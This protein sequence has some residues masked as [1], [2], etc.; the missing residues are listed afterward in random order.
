[1][2]DNIK[3]NLSTT[4]VSTYAFEPLVGLTAATNPRGISTQYTYDNA[5]R[6]STVT[7]TKKNVVSQYQYGYVDISASTVQTTNSMLN[8]RIFIS[9]KRFNI[10][11]A[12]IANVAVVGGSGNYTYD[13]KLMNSSGTILAS[14]LN[15]SSTSFSYSYSQGGAM[16]IQCVVTDKQT[17]ISFT[18]LTSR[19]VN[20]ITGSFTMYSGYNHITSSITNYGTYASFYFAFYPSGT[21]NPMTSYLVANVSANCRPS[22]QQIIRYYGD[23]TWDITINPNGDVY[24]KII[25]G[26]G[27]S[28]SPLTGGVGFGTITYPL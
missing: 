8:A 4:L 22:V 12:D 23:K 3:T 9:S 5:N 2:I 19:T 10:G 15:S 24:F 27:G 14:Q 20:Y 11:D 25:C 17:G 26:G 28:C 1:L 18:T 7:D 16:T 6:L 21:M 13:W